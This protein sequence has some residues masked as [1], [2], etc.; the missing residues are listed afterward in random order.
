VD[1]ILRGGNWNAV[2]DQRDEYCAAVFSLDIE[3]T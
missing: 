3:T 2:S 1:Q